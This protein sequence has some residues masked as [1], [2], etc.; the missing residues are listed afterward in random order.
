MGM[1]NKNNKN[2]QKKKVSPKFN[3]AQI[4]CRSELTFS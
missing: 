4:N 1:T 2:E 3:V